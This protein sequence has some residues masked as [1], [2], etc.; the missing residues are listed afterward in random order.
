MPLK[1]RSA[2]PSGPTNVAA[3]LLRLFRR[4]APS[5]LV[6]IECYLDSFYLIKA[7]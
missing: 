7:L 6:N 5:P 3:S 4:Y 1:R 2:N